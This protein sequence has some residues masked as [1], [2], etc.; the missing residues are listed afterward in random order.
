MLSAAA[1]RFSA[2]AT[3]TPG[4]VVVITSGKGG[5]GK[6]TVSASFAYGLALRG[7]K[8]CVVDF[9]VGLR[10]L[11][12][13]LGAERR[14]IFDFVNVMQVLVEALVFWGEGHRVT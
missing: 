5:V 6:T 4:R 11:D 13:H 14:V 12:L 7:H 10:N 2:P 9:D 1:R 8:T 3:K